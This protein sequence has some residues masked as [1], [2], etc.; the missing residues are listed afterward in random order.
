VLAIPISAFHP[1]VL[2][3]VTSS[4]P[5]LFALSSSG[6]WNPTIHCPF[7]V[8]VVVVVVKIVSCGIKQILVLS[9]NEI[10]E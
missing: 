8:V 4:A 9:P 1:V 2:I 6:T 7:L 10:F 5:P 3:A